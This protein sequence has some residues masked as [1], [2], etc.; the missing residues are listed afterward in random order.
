MQDALQTLSPQCCSHY[1]LHHMGWAVF[2]LLSRRHLIY[3]PLCPHSQGS[4]EGK[5]QAMMV[6][7]SAF[8]SWSFKKTE[9]HL[10]LSSK[11]FGLELLAPLMQWRLC[12][13]DAASRLQIIKICE[14]SFTFTFIY[15]CVPQYVA[16]FGHRHGKRII[17]QLIVRI[18]S[19]CTTSTWLDY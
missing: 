10:F 17:A 13:K 15:V 9:C 18:S 7:E 14:S 12:L 16:D 3:A 1:V 19:L 11:H 6:L 8:I 4:G 5:E 2:C